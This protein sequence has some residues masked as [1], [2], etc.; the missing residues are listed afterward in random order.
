[1]RVDVKGVIVRHD[2]AWIYDYFGIACVTPKM[3]NDVV[4]QASETGE[5]LDVYINSDGGEIFSAS[6]MYAALREYGNVRIHV[7]GIAASA[8]SVLMCAGYSD[9][10]PTS[11]VMVHNVRSSQEGDY[12]DMRHES[13]TLKSASKAMAAAYCEKSGMTMRQAL[14]LMDK[15]TFLT[16]EEAVQYGLVDKIAEYTDKTIPAP[17]ALVAVSGGMIP[18][19]IIQE[20]QHRRMKMQNQLDILKLKGESAI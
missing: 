10:S 8:A 7:T 13:D 19:E 16:A 9:I 2:V 11:M 17:S 5:T 15:E 14:D 12:R 20:Y 1:M 4:S 6:E 18:N 3:I